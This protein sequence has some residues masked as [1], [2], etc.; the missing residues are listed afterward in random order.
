[1]SEHTSHKVEPRIV[2]RNAF[3]VGGLRYE[4]KNQNR[5]IPARISN[6]PDYLS[7]FPST[8]QVRLRNRNGKICQTCRISLIY[9]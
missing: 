9:P 3:L 4:G 1:M 8:A 5:E 7:L 2:S 6:R